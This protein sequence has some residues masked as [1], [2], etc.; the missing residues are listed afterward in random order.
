MQ[1][2]IRLYLLP[3]IALFNIRLLLQHISATDISHLQ[4]APLHKESI[5]C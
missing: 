3:T 1:L 5:W 2:Y 4:G